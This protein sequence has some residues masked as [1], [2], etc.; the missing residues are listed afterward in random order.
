MI[1]FLSSVNSHMCHKLSFL[2]KTLS[3]LITCEQFLSSVDV[4]VKL[5]IIFACQSLSTLSAGEIF[6]GSYFL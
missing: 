4:H 2:S 3:A 5:K 1:R 6:L